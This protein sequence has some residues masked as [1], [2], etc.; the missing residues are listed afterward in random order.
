M[1]DLISI[2]S[3]GLRAYQAA[4]GTTSD[5]IA[6]AQTAGYVRR[7]VQLKEAAPGANSP[8]YR[9]ATSPGGVLVGGVVRS[10]DQWLV[11]DARS[12]SSAAARTGV[13]SDWMSATERAL[14]DGPSSAG[15]A[16]TAV[17]NA[18]DNLAADPTNNAAR[19]AFLQ[20]VA[21]ASDTFRTTAEKLTSVGEGI[22]GVSKDTVAQF[23]SD[24]QA[25]QKVNSSLLRSRD[26]STS[27][28]SLL[29]DRD[30]LLDQLASVLPLKATFDSHGAATVEYS[31]GGGTTL[32]DG[33]SM[34]VL[35]LSVGGD[36]QID[37]ALNGSQIQP[38]SGK[39]SGLI[40]AAAHNA[41]QIAGLDQLA[42]QFAAQ[43][44]AAHTAGKDATGAAGLPLVTFGGTA[45]TLFANSLSP[46]QV[47]A[48][49]GSSDNGNMLAFATMRGP[50]GVEQGWAQL[51]ASQAQS[52][53]TAKAEDAAAS[54]RRDGAAQARSE[55]SAVDLDREA[56]ELM[57]FQQAYQASA[58]V[59]QVARDTFQSILSAF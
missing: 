42:S 36:N 12:S 22:V 47:A 20:S 50:G 8:L 19:A 33:S 11:E 53:S 17:F 24:L 35:S 40:S 56:A 28:A 7:T 39:A 43:I 30:R 46:A 48:A 55:L 2:G 32:L 25:L 5:N 49:D 23:N 44:N 18:A 16:T 10:I 31:G 54:S 57:R 58:R 21:N 3:S 51:A 4:L 38:A 27:Q 14:N 1:T 52:V 34:S 45:A 59:I 29:D 13:R 9:A 41:E 15:A 26:G 6:N 37:F